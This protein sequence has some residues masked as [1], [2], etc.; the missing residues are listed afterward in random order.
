MT[1]QAC[2]SPFLSLI[3]LHQ[4]QWERQTNLVQA[5]LWNAIVQ[6]SHQYCHE[7]RIYARQC[8][9]ERL[10]SPQAQA[11]LQQHHMW[12]SVAARYSYGLWFNETLV[13]VATFSSRRR[14][15]RG[16]KI[17]R[18]HELL[19][20]CTQCNVTVLGGCSKL[21]KAFE[22]DVQPDDIVTV[23]DRD[24]TST[25]HDNWKGFY[26]VHTRAPLPLAV[27]EGH[28]Y[29]LIGA[30]YQI[31]A[32]SSKAG[33]QRQF[34][35]WSVYQELNECQDAP[36]AQSCLESHGYHLLYDAGV[37]RLLKIVSEDS[38]TDIAVTELYDNSIPQYPP[39]YYSPNAGISALLRQAEEQCK[40]NNNDV[41]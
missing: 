6:T 39:S 31:P 29:H 30:S 24:W 28:R 10:S 1:N 5:R 41:K 17:Y 11:F 27:R 23:L 22:R 33:L 20:F 4:D 32:N 35:P 40:V 18:S 19:R 16:S 12:S 15:Q 34:V 8:R 21:V 36:S 26:S 14:I 3:H 2:Q 7:R 38:L 25:R 9:V 37:E 13:A